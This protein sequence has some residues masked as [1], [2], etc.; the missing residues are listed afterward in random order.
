MCDK[1]LVQSLP[2]GNAAILAIKTNL[3]SI[4]IIWIMNVKSTELQLIIKGWD[5]KAE[6]Q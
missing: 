1:F 5:S 4:C 3:E 2:C 6:I